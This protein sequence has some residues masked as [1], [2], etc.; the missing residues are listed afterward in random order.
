MFNRAVGQ[1]DDYPIQVRLGAIYTLREIERDFPDLAGA[2]FELLSAYIRERADE[3][4]GGEPPADVR[5]VFA[6]LRDRLT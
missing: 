1:L 2:V 5:E 4:G 6:M 3:Y